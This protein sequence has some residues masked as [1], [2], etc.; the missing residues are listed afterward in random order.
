VLC[1][2]A[3]PGGRKSAWVECVAEVDCN[4]LE[5]LVQCIQVMLWG[6]DL[7]RVQKCTGDLSE[8]EAQPKG[9]WKLSGGIDFVCGACVEA[10][11]CRVAEHQQVAAQAPGWIS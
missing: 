1:C 10:C 11:K 5:L 2:R 4:Q 9:A 6:L 7:W 8:A 3:P